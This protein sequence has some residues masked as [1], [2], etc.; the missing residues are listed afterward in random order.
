[1]DHYKDFSD[2]FILDINQY[3]KEFSMLEQPLSG[4]T[5]QV[6]EFHKRAVEAQSHSN[7]VIDSTLV[8]CIVTDFKQSFIDRAEEVCT[9]LKSHVKL[10]IDHY[11]VVYT[12]ILQILPKDLNKIYMWGIKVLFYFI[13]NSYLFKKIKMMLIKK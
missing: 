4:Y 11:Y 12:K 10:Y 9:R 2:L 7:N 8:R 1:M 6:D 13:I 3:M 5:E